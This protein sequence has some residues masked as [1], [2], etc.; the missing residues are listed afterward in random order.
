MNEPFISLTPRFS[1][2]VLR[3]G[4]LNRFNGFLLA[5]ETVET[6][7]RRASC[8]ITSLK[9]GVNDNQAETGDTSVKFL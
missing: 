9:R 4:G 1:G 2:V 8:Q 7:L 3:C 5:A 6:V